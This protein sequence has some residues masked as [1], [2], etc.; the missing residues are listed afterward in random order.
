MYT[1]TE[2]WTPE[3]HDPFFD[4]VIEKAR[5]EMN[6]QNP[7]QLIH[8]LK[9]KVSRSDE[10]IVYAILNGNDP[11]ENSQYSTTDA[12]VMFNPFANTATANMLVRSEFLRLAAKEADVRDG[13][14]KLKPIIM[15]AS[16][17]VHGSKLKLSR[18]EKRAIGEGKLGPAAK[19]YLKAIK[20]LDFG[21][22]AL[23][24]FS[25]GADMALAGARKSEESDL[26]AES[27][28]IGDPASVESRGLKVLAQDFY[29]AAPDLEMTAARSGLEALDQARH[30]K[31]GYTQFAMSALYPAN[32]YRLAKGLGDNSFEA[33]MQAVLDSEQLDKIVVGYGGISTIS[34][35]KYIEPALRRLKTNFEDNRLITIRVTDASHA[36]GD[37]LTLLAKLYLKSII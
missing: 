1:P 11:N 8:D 33:T 10:G 4:Y 14:G 9:K 34:P 7:E 21:R 35:P 32:W 19:E 29:A 22:I 15:L 12:L 28:S 25:Q 17:G 31:G 30:E 6:S 37:D 26:D 3:V 13:D 5:H 18:E 24:G 2:I 36:W 16:P 20:G 27:M 23:L